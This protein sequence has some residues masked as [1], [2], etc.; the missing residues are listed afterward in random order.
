MTD[1]TVKHVDGNVRRARVP[2]L[3]LE[4]LWCCAG[5]I[6]GITEV[7]GHSLIRCLTAII[8]ARGKE[9]SEIIMS[10]QCRG[11]RKV[12]FET[13]EVYLG[14][15]VQTIRRPMVPPGADFSEC[16]VVEAA[17]QATDLHFFGDESFRPN[18]RVLT[19]A[20]E[21]E[22][23]LNSFGR[24]NARRTLVAGL[25]DRLRAQDLFD[26]HPEVLRR[27]LG[28]MV[29]IVGAARS[30]TTRTHRLIAQDTRFL[31]L[32]DWEINFPVPTAKC[33]GCN[34]D[35]RIARA[36]A[37]HEAVKEM[38]PMN[39]SIHPLD[40]MAPEEEIGLLN[41]S[42]CGMMLESQFWIPTFG[43]WC[44]ETEQL[45]AY[46]YMKKLLQ[47]IA[48]FRGDPVN[49]PWVLK[50]PQH[51]QD[52]G[53]LIKVFP[54]AKIVFVHR[55][56]LKTI[57]SLSSLVWNFIILGTDRHDP[58]RLGA[59]YLD[60]IDAQIKKTTCA[61]ETLLPEH[62]QLDVHYKA[63]MDDWQGEIRPIYDFIAM[64]LTPDTIENM[65]QWVTADQ[66]HRSQ[67]HKYAS[68]DFGPSENMVNSHF[69]DYVERYG[70]DTEGTP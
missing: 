60:K 63:M 49:K 19:R 22:A 27:K 5:I 42:F 31:H 58:A 59:Y 57:P 14:D 37:V 53:S 61:R 11:K 3:E 29:V 64:E 56:P 67:S 46:Q 25:S 70:I 36:R 35:P 30:G 51:M 52:I 13:A 15:K 6:R 18:L 1:T 33:F 17:R 28:P 55:D 24:L 10:T 44:L 34:P 20:M 41:M 26:R 66:N 32:R 39:A 69:I 62:Q 48:W 47:L 38:N 12:E 40:A 4:T 7:I 8:A 43:R 65:E 2:A 54:D 16:S 9:G 21:E 23:E 68:S 45:A 50:S